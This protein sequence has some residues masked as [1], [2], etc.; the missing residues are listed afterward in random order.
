M[1]STPLAGLPANMTQHPRVP[2]NTTTPT[3]RS[4]KTGKKARANRPSAQ[5]IID[6]K[7][8]DKCRIFDFLREEGYLLNE[9]T[10]WQP[11]PNGQAFLKLRDVSVSVYNTG[12]ILWQGN[13]GKYYEDKFKHWTP[14]AGEADTLCANGTVI[15]RP[16]EKEEV[17]LVEL[18][19]QIVGR[20]IAREHVDEAVH[21]EHESKR[22]DRQ[23]A[24][25][26]RVL[27]QRDAQLAE[28]DAQ[29]AVKNVELEA[30]KKQLEETCAQHACSD[31]EAT[32]TKFEAHD[33]PANVLAPTSPEDA[34]SS[35]DPPEIGALTF[36]TP[37]CITAKLVLHTDC[38]CFHCRPITTCCCTR[39][40]VPPVFIR[41]Q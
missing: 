35:E 20:L 38:C 37:Q 6:T 28:R 39:W 3:K 2:S 14:A 19:G 31:S 32:P 30:L 18:G 4:A 29:L 41:H 36:H 21:L 16:V 5:E 25:V 17:K 34:A 8:R 23:L 27:Q 11:K 40:R 22:P 26:Q 12:T 24:A 10:E 1:A 33:A 9:V 7:S 13:R 15:I